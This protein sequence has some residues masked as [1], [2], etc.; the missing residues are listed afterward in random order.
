MGKLQE[1]QCFWCLRPERDF[2]SP[3]MILTL[4]G[5]PLTLP[6]AILT[7]R[8]DRP[9]SDFELP[10]ATLTLRSGPPDAL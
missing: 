10:D 9:G 1:N 2:D 7:L 4:L 5:T 6:D 3:D 8:N